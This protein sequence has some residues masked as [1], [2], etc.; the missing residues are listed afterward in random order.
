ML[1]SVNAW[2]VF[3]PNISALTTCITCCVSMPLTIAS[4]DC[5]DGSYSTSMRGFSPAPNSAAPAAS[6]KPAGITIAAFWLPFATAWRACAASISVMC[7][8]ASAFNA[9][10]ILAPTSPLS[11]WTSATSMVPPLAGPEPPNR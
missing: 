8:V 1:L 5:C 3:P 7:S 2:P 11:C 10:A 6:P 9:A 4:T